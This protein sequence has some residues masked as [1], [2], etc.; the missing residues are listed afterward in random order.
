MSTAERLLAALGGASIAAVLGYAAVRA[1][2]VAFFPE[3]NPA[4]VIWS[5]RSGFVWRVVLSLYIAGMG[6]FGGYALAARSPEST[7]RW[8]ARGALL[9]AVALAAQSVALP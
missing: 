2:E 1:V 5:E 8:M 3:P 6:A 7:G 4:I 9:A